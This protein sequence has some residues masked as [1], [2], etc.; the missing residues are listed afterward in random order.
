MPIPDGPAARTPVRPGWGPA[1]AAGLVVRLRSSFRGSTRRPSG[2]S[3]MSRRVQ[4]FVVIAIIVVLVF[5][6]IAS[7]AE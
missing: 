2:V 5:A 4:R 6:L 1:R 3:D 7:F